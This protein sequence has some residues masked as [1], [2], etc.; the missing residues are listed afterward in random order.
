MCVCVGGG[1]GGGGGASDRKRLDWRNLCET[2]KMKKIDQ[3][4]PG[5]LLV[6]FGSRR[7]HLGKNSA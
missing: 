3:Y 2:D 4:S 7:P 1:G 6:Y 5:S